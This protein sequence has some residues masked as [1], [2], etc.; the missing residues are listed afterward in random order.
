[1]PPFTLICLLSSKTNLQNP[2]SSS[3]E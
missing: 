2:L 3:K 1:M